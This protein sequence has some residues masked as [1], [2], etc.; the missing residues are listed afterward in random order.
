[1]KEAL[2]V[3]GESGN[4]RGQV[5]LD[6]ADGDP[7]KAVMAIA[8]IF[9][10]DSEIDGYVAT[11][12]DLTK[13]EELEARVRRGERLSALGTLAGGI[14]HD[15]N[16]LLVPILGYTDLVRAEGSG[17]V[18]AYLDGIT[19]ASERA[20]DLVQRIMIFGRGGSG[21]MVALDLRFEIEDSIAFLRSLLPTTIELQQS[22]SDVGT[23]LADKTQIQQLLLNL[24]S[25]AGEA[26]AETGGTLLIKLEARSVG[27]AGDAS[28]PELS[29]GEY[30]VLTVTDSG[31][32]MTEEVK[33]KIFDP[34]FSGRE[35]DG[36]T[37]LG[38]AIVHGIVSRHSG[39]VQV[40]STPGVGTSFQVF[41]PT[42]GVEPTPNESASSGGMPRGN[43]ETIMLVDDDELVL[44]TLKKMLQGLGYEISAWSDPHAALNAFDAEPGAFAAV[45][46]DQTMPGL[47]GLALLKKIANIRPDI[48]VA[49]LTGNVGALQDYDGNVISKP[50]PLPELADLLRD[51]LRSSEVAS[52]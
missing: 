6:R 35:G 26:M 12:R 25:N 13:E 50:M 39:F 31:V 48:P 49:I 41:L 32:G 42:V 34:Y 14:A 2:G 27:K 9:G 47:T 46:A 4:W 40:D 51:L 22:L 10:D 7:L 21:E 44:S 43:G 24:C 20:R 23:V 3:V 38:L 33:A 17:N 16:N 15:F 28:F 52:A 29:P 30:A 5:L 19:K 18:N 8:P 1:M 45:L 11:A 37:G 36:G